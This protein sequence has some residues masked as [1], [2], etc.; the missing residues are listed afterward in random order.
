MFSKF[1]WNHD[2]DLDAVLDEHYK[3]M[4]GAGAKD[5]EAF[6]DALEKIWIGKVAIPSVIGETEFGPIMYRGPDQ[7]DLKKTSILQ[8]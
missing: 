1:A 5:M 8:P 7:N 6:F 4:F 3:L 2:I